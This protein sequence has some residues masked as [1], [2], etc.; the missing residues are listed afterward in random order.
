MNKILTNPKDGSE[1]EI[2][3]TDEKDNLYPDGWFNF[4]QATSHVNSRVQPKGVWRMPTLEEAEIIHQDIL[5]NGNS[6]FEND[7]YWTSN[8]D[9]VSDAFMFN[10]SNGET[11]SWLKTS[12]KRIRLVRTIKE[13]S[14]PDNNNSNSHQ[15]KASGCLGLIVFL[16]G[17][18]GIR[19]LK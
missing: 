13:G 11:M 2:R 6:N 10:F 5:K 3:P 1:F 14:N 18:V 7:Y 8:T 4:Y 17:M 19:F 12:L 16:I 9:G 15:A